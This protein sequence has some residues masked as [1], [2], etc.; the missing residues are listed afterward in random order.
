[1][2]SVIV[3]ACEYVS[4]SAVFSIPVCKYPISTSALTIISPSSSRSTRNTPCVEGCWGPMLR[5]MVF[6]R[7]VAVC[8]VVMAQVR[9]SQN[10]KSARALHGII[11]AERIAFPIV[12]QQHAPQ[13]GVSFKPNA[14][15]VKDFAFMPIRRRPNG[16]HRL[17]D[18]ILARKM[19]PKTN[20]FTPGERQQMIIQFEAGFDGKSVHAG[21]VGEVSEG[22]VGFRQQK[23]RKRPQ[24]LAIDH[25]GNLT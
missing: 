18:R 15:E 14:K 7:P 2:R 8:T 22:Q 6:S 11:L 10:R 21:H 24:M 4:A 20:R 9:S 19:N 12:G 13:I 1:M 25:N 3:M 23:F 17:G 16:Y 5:T